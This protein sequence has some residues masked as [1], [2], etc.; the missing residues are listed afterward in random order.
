MQR[1]ASGVLLKDI[2]LASPFFESGSS[3]WSLLLAVV[4]PLCFFVLTDVGYEP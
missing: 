3:N 4:V 2:G 1:I